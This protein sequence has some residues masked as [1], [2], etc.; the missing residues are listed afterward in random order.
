MC[1]QFLDEGR[2][3]NSLTAPA[4]ILAARAYE[5]VYTKWGKRALDI[6]F[7]ALGLLVLSP[8]FVIVGCIIKLSSS[9]GTF[10]RQTRIGKA[11]CHFQILKFRSMAVG[12]ANSGL[13]ITVAGDSRVT[14]VGRVLRRHKLDELPQLWNVLRGDMSLVGPRPEL[15]IYVAAY[16][17]DQRRVLS[18]R[19]GIT[20]PASLVYRHEEEILA[21]HSDPDIFYRTQVLPDKLVRNL[22]YVQA[23]SVK[24]DLRII[25]ETLVSSFLGSQKVHK[26]RSV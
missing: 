17:D 21:E 20:D 3:Q 13:E 4:P 14:R 26:H 7:S 10:Y 24:N 5:N 25:F 6:L 1:P 8:F 9:G 12:R 16:T 2:A 18:V 11:G 23:I 22:A 19:P 15:P